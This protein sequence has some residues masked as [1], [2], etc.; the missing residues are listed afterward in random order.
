MFFHA[1][2]IVIPVRPKS[3]DERRAHSVWTDEMDKFNGAAGTVVHTNGL[4]WVSFETGGKVYY[5]R[6][7]WL[8]KAPEFKPN[9]NELD[10]LFKECDL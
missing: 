6:P 3:Y 9:N 5:Y 10:E 8:R 2:D 1:G 7:S 4:I